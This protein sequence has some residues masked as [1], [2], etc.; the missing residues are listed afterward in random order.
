MFAK[1]WVPKRFF[2]GIAELAAASMQRKDM[3]ACATDIAKMMLD[4][5][6]DPHG[7]DLIEEMDKAAN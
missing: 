6:G 3:D 4:N 2:Y 7:D 5:D 1:G